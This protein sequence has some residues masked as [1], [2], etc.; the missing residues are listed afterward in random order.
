MLD[1]SY[2]GPGI[3]CPMGAMYWEQIHCAR[4]SLHL[5][6]LISQATDGRGLLLW[7][8]R[9]RRV[10]C[11]VFSAWVSQRL[12]LEVGD[13]G[14]PREGVGVTLGERDTDAKTSMF[15]RFLRSNPCKRF[16]GFK[17]SQSCRTEPRSHCEFFQFL[18]IGGDEISIRSTCYARPDTHV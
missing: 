3:L 17:T 11:L 13:F 8:W 10:I 12:L 1:A 2:G 16:V 6:E 4:T 15:S 14:A 5:H 9:R 7:P 18:L